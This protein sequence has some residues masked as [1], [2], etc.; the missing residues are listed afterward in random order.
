MIHMYFSTASM[1][2]VTF[3]VVFIYA[4]AFSPALAAV[5]GVYMTFIVW[6][7]L[8]AQIAKVLAIAGIGMNLKGTD[9]GKLSQLVNACSEVDKTFN[10]LFFQPEQVFPFMRFVFV[11]TSTYQTYPALCRIAFEGW[12]LPEST[13]DGDLNCLSTRSGDA[14]LSSFGFDSVNITTN[15][16]LLFARWVLYYGIAYYLFNRAAYGW[17]LSGVIPPFLRRKKKPDGDKDESASSQDAIKADAA[18]FPSQLL[19]RRRTYHHTSNAARPLQRTKYQSVHI[20]PIAALAAVEHSES[21]TSQKAQKARWSENSEGMVQ[22]RSQQ[23]EGDIHSTANW[24]KSSALPCVSATIESA[25]RPADVRPRLKT[26]L[27]DH[28]HAHHRHHKQR[29]A[30][31]ALIEL[32]N[33]LLN[34]EHQ[35]VLNIVSERLLGRISRVSRV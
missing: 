6:M 29:G 9:K 33:R 3:L 30:L 1:P 34:I 15:A 20:L 16:I 19:V 27:H 35:A 11:L 28:E 4:M 8:Q 10:G 13:C 31:N 2:I 12:A 32:E 21:R 5:R 14:F 23:S 22:G 17:R 25:V 24:F 26:D 7:D 18:A